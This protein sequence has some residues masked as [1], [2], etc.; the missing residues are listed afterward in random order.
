MAKAEK[1]LSERLKD[2]S[3]EWHK[4]WEQGM[5]VYV[6]MDRSGSVIEADA[7]FHPGMVEVQKSKPDIRWDL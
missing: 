7:V 6:R 5:T 4:K 2:Y 3:N 1:P